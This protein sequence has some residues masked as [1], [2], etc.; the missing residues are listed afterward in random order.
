[1]KSIT[2]VSRLLAMPVKTIRYYDDIGLLGSVSRANNGYRQFNETNIA[3]LRLIQSARFAG[4]SI[5]ES[6]ELIAL[7][8]DNNRASKEVKALTSEKIRA[9]KEKINE[10]NNV[11]KNL[12]SLHDACAGDEQSQCSIL[13]G[14]SKKT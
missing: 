3:Q 14:L 1:M 13:D 5:D 11:V 7:F 6:K 4:F 10:L 8:N 2:Q 9:L 12:E